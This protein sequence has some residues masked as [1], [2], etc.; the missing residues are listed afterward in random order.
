MQTLKDDPNDLEVADI[1]LNESLKSKQTLPTLDD[2]VQKILFEKKDKIHEV[3][4]RY[5]VANELIGSRPVK[6]STWLVIIYTLGNIQ[7]PVFRGREGQAKEKKNH[8]C[9]RFVQTIASYQGSV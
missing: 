9:L 8:I 1:L 5:V 6:S 2:D 7:R 4:R 3:E